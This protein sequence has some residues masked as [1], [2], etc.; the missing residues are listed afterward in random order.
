MINDC[1]NGYFSYLLSVSI[2]AVL[3][4]FW[5]RERLTLLV[6]YLIVKLWLCYSC[7]AMSKEKLSMAGSLSSHHQESKRK[8]KQETN[9]WLWVSSDLSLL[10]AQSALPAC[11]PACLPAYASVV[12][13]TTAGRLKASR[14]T[15]M[16][17]RLR[18]EISRNSGHDSGGSGLAC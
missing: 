9:P 12:A 8:K 7:T 16:C 5:Q 15:T 17:S 2:S 6:R 11:F 18:S 14:L 13:H 10:Q 3:T 4:F 1:K